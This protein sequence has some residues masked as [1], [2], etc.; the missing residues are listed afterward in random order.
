M[1]FHRFSEALFKSENS[2]SLFGNLLEHLF[3]DEFEIFSVIEFGYFGID[4]REV[5]FSLIVVVDLIE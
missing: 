3:E 4:L 1:R 5:D 2:D